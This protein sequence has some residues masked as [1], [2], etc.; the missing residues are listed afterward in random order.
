VEDFEAGLYVCDSVFGPAIEYAF[1]GRAISKLMGCEITASEIVIVVSK[2]ILKSHGCNL[3]RI[4]KK[5]PDFFGIA[6]DNSQLVLIRGNK[7]IPLR[8]IGVGEDHYPPN[9][10]PPLNSSKFKT[11]HLGRQQTYQLHSLRSFESYQVPIISPRYL[12]RR[13]LVKLNEH[14]QKEKYK[15]EGSDM[16][17]IN[18]LRKCCVIPQSPVDDKFCSDDCTEVLN[19]LRQWIQSGNVFFYMALEAEA[20]EWNRLGL[21]LPSEYRF[22][23]CTNQQ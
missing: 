21:A 17:I 8:F 16:E 2:K 7:G 12:L 19:I 23:Y 15:I 1:G 20:K 6:Q 5:R 11:K 14:V 4:A 18:L 3:V 22:Q 13:K 10:I 9:L